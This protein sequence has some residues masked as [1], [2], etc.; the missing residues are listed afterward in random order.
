MTLWDWAVEVY[1]RPGVAEA[2][3][4][5]QDPFG[6]Q[7]SYLLWSAWAR[8][9][10]AAR[11]AHAADVARGWDARV[12]APLRE[13]RRAL[14]PAAPPFDDLGRER[15]RAAAQAAELAAEQLLLQTLAAI[16]QGHPAGFAPRL[17]A[18]VAAAQA[19]GA[20]PPREALESLARALDAGLPPAAEPRHDRAPDRSLQT[21]MDD[22]EDVQWERELRARLAAVTQDHADLDVAIQA[23]T[24]AAMPDMM[25]IGRLKRKKLAL[26]DEIARLQDQLTP[27]IIA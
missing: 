14:K 7:V 8:S 1:A 24:A 25:V 9:L 2:C 17:E 19:W 10:D 23:L 18:L 13:V 12:I 16:S 26:K 21:P 22:E 6:Q 11:L 27:D 15:V 5:L 3:L 4:E 20:P